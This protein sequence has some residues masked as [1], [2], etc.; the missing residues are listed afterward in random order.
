M[1]IQIWAFMYRQFVKSYDPANLGYFQ[2][3]GETGCPG[4]VYIIELAQLYSLGAK[5]MYK[6]SFKFLTDHVLP[7]AL[8]VFFQVY[9]DMSLFD[10]D[11]YEIENNVRLIL[12]EMINDGENEKIHNIFHNE[13]SAMEDGQSYEENKRRFIEFVLFSFTLTCLLFVKFKHQLQMDRK[14]NSVITL[15]EESL[16]DA[17]G[18]LI[19]YGL[20]LGF[21]TIQFMILG[22]VTTTEDYPNLN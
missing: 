2:W 10:Y 16:F 3:F 21:F 9:K 12:Q 22:S 15:I 18:F 19:Y 7:I 11:S 17:F 6:G 14:L 4:I 13:A 5:K 1:I 20:L 8:I